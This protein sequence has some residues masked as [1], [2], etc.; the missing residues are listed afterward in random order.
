MPRYPRPDRSTYT[1]NFR[2][3]VEDPAL[4]IGWAEWTLK[5]G[6]P[7]R[8]ECWAEDG[9]TSLTFFFSSKRMESLSDAD[10]AALLEAE[11]LLRFTGDR[12]YVASG[13]FTDAAGNA[14]WSV[15]VVVGDEDGTFIVDKVALRA[16]AR[17]LAPNAPFLGSEIA[18]SAP[19]ILLPPLLAPLI[20]NQEVVR[21]ALWRPSGCNR[22]KVFLRKQR[23]MLSHALGDPSCGHEGRDQV[24]DRNHPHCGAAGLGE[25]LVSKTQGVL[26]REPVAPRQEQYQCVALSKIQM[27]DV[28]AQLIVQEKVF[29]LEHCRAD[30]AGERWRVLLAE[31]RLSPLIRKALSELV[32]RQLDLDQQSGAAVEF[33]VKVH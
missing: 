12:R 22:R 9:I 10:F 19:R 13:A 28:P 17:P 11:D 16:Y 27:A 5:D 14:M 31:L 20:P 6:R 21:Q 18:A 23:E 30:L 2:K 32:L 1:P 33:G 8:A 25:L 15:N 26:P 3:T 29:L 4:D 7:W 24:L